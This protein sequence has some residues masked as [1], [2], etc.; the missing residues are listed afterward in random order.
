MNF[1]AETGYV[2]LQIIIIIQREIPLKHSY[3]C[4]LADSPYRE[5]KKKNILHSLQ[6]NKFQQ[7]L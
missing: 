2:D 3:L 6:K 5:R 1:C 7:V 4:M